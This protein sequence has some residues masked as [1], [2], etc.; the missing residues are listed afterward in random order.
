MPLIDIPVAIAI[1]DDYQN[2]ALQMADWSRLEGKAKIT[3]FNDHIADTD[4][5]VERLQPFDVLCVMRE[6]TL[7]P[8]SSW[9]KPL[10][11]ARP[12]ATSTDATCDGAKPTRAETDQTIAWSA[13]AR[14]PVATARLWCTH[15]P[16]LRCRRGVAAASSSFWQ[17]PGQA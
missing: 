8:A 4:A 11:G 16:R 5:L 9:A 15:Q 10:N 6:R 3:V 7:L 2:V 1:L 12:L 14:G 13:P 17:S